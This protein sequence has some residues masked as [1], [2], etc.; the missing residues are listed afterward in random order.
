[1]ASDRGGAPQEDP[2]VRVPVDEPVRLSLAA[3]LSEVAAE[4]A[5]I[6]K[7]SE[8]KFHKYK[9]ASAAAVLRRVNDALAKRRIATS[10]DFQLVQSDRHPNGKDIITV[11][12][13][14]LAF[15]DGDSS[16]VLL[17]TAFGAG[18]DTGEKSWMKSTTVA[19]KYALLYA[20]NIATGDDPEADESVDERMD[21]YK[22]DP[23]APHRTPDSAI[24]AVGRGLSQVSQ[25]QLADRLAQGLA[26]LVTR[27]ALET[28]A[29]RARQ[30]LTDDEARANFGRKWKERMKALGFE[31][32]RTQPATTTT[33]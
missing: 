10:V 30:D 4:C 13:A 19:H 21:Q 5:Y 7:D 32:A 29:A 14:T 17:T 23:D 27:E 2:A 6:Q 3:K 16:E 20:L 11:V 18:Q 28:L 26:Q 15:H 22:R 9:F 12:R 1:M 31:V 8:N 25:L 24:D 33:R